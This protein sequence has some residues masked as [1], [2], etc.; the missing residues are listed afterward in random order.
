MFSFITNLTGIIA[1]ILNI[2]WAFS[3]KF[4]NKIIKC[5]T[6]LKNCSVIVEASFYFKIKDVEKTFDFELFIKELFDFFKNEEI[7]MIKKTPNKNAYFRIAYNNYFFTYDGY[8][9]KLKIDKSPTTYR[10]LKKHVKDFVNFAYRIN[11]ENSP[12]NNLIFDYGE[13]KSFFDKKN[14]YISFLVKESFDLKK[15][16]MILSNKNDKNSEII[17]KENALILY[18]TRLDGFAILFNA[19]Y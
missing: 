13:L 1:T 7:Q 12:F 11:S 4:R 16:E 14:P 18:S 8:D 6:Y 9:L 15:F 3:L 19:W 5:W 17:I 2:L 10:L